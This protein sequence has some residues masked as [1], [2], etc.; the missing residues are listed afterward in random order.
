[1]KN[2]INGKP[3]E[4]GN[5]DQIKFLKKHEENMIE[6]VEKGIATND[7]RIKVKASVSYE[8]SFNCFQCGAV[9]KRYEVQDIDPME[10]VDDILEEL[11]ITCRS[12][13]CQYA[14]DNGIIMITENPVRPDLVTRIELQ[15]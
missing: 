4:F 8:L 11:E 13:K 10:S 9:V 6:M 5:T 1:M 2:F 7:G 15:L 12:C 14:A 3:L